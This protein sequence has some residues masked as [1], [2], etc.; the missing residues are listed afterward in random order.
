MHASGTPFT[1]PSGDRLRAWMRVTPDEFYDGR[2]VAIVPMGF[3]FPGN[4]SKGGDRPPRPECATAWHARLFGLMPNLDL[5]L[6]VGLAAI[7]WHLPDRAHPTL[8]ET[9]ANWRSFLAPAATRTHNHALAL[10]LPHPSWR[11]TGWLKT[12]PWFEDEV[13]PVVRARVRERIPSSAG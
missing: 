7:R 5:F 1:D 8:R 10:P 13:L 4:D 6:L 3:C 9:V 2:H 12:H 11:N